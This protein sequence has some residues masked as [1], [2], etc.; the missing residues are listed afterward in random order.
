MASTESPAEPQVS[1]LAGCQSLSHSNSPVVE[2]VKYPQDLKIPFTSTTSDRSAPPSCSWQTSRRRHSLIA[3]DVLPIGLV[4]HATTA[5]YHLENISDSRPSIRRSASCATATQT[6]MAVEKVQRWS[7]MTRTVSDWDGLRRDTELWFEDGDC[8]VHLYAQGASRRGPSF[9]VPFRALRQKKCSSL[10]NVCHAQ[11]ASRDGSE[12]QQL[13][14]LSSS[15]VLP[16]REPGIVNLY[17]PAPD[18]V[19]R[20]DAFK[21]HI[22]TRNFFAFLLGKPLVGYHMGQTFVDLQER[23]HMYRSGLIDNHQDFLQYAEDQGYR[24]FAECTDYALATL[25][26]AETYK[27]RHAWIDAFAHCVGMNESLSLSPEYNAISRLTKALITRAFLEVDLHLGQVTAALSKFLEEDFSPAYLGLTPGARSH[28]NR[29]RRFLHS[30]YVKK[31]GYWPPPRGSTFPKAL[32]KSMYFDFQSLYNYLVDTNSTTDFASQG[33][34][35]GGICVLQNVDSFDKRHKFPSQPHPLP[36]LPSYEESSKEIKSQRALRQLTL[37]AQHNKVNHVQTIS[38]ALAVATNSP[39]AAINNSSIVKEY[40][41]FER[42]YSATLN[43][44]DEKVSVVDA[45]KARWLLIYGTLQYLVSALRAPKEVRDTETA[46]YPLC[47]LLPEQSSWPGSSQVS[48]PSAAMMTGCALNAP[49]AI[50]EYLNSAQTEFTSIQP[51]CHREDYFSSRTS[52]LRGSVEV[53]AP[54]KISTPV[55]NLPSRSFGSISLSGRSSRRNSLKLNPT[56]HCE[57]IVRGYGNG[58]NQATTESPDQGLSRSASANHSHR[59]SVSILPE[60]AGPE[61][62]WI[63]PQSPPVP[64][65]RTSSLNKARHSRQRTPLLDAALLERFY[66]YAITSDHT[67]MSRSDSTS[68]YGS[69]VWSEASAVSSNSS[70]DGEYQERHSFTVEDSGLLGGLVSVENT[71]VPTPRTR[72]LS[73]PKAP[74]PPPSA[75]IVSHMQAFRFDDETPQA[76][77]YDD[78]HPA[79]RPP[80]ADTTIGMALSPSASPPVSPITNLWAS[81]FDDAPEIPQD[82]PSHTM[83]RTITS[84][85]TYADL[86]ISKVIKRSASHREQHGLFTTISSSGKDAEKRASAERTKNRLSILKRFYA[87]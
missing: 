46:D 61:T 14:A 56:N 15:L 58:L 75:P 81:Y 71:P 43:Q 84:D 86:P 54:L 48:T 5:G 8:Y 26:Y 2:D 80:N 32:Y 59:S 66:G 47:C 82:T 39:R 11:I 20:Q 36:L 18:D 41:H 44:R 60:G 17:I 13:L 87:F 67:D 73:K 68:S 12:T 57:I 85:L 63:R 25:Y 33:P 30:F 50:D 4:E 45:R 72:S 28:L 16:S 9:C 22:T 35:S 76:P 23:L 53:P 40:A 51:D 37:A 55:S 27:L 70:L 24:D 1:I 65:E 7:G 77:N 38:A 79:F 69:Q 62:S 10:L 29:F 21:W 31:F 83:T 3:D 42:A 64:Q 6:S 49:Q 34:A 78:V 52:S 19:S 74:A